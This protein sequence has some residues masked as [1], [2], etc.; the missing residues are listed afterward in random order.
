M[1]YQEVIS[2]IKGKSGVYDI[3]TL[4]G[5][6][7]RRLFLSQN[8]L[9]CEFAPRSRK[10]GYPIDS[11][12]IACWVSVALYT[13]NE[14]NIVAKF[15]RYASRATFPSAFVRKCLVAD[16]SK[17]CYENRLTT[18][19]R[20]D[21]EIISLNAIERFNPYSVRQ[22]RKALKER[23]NYHSSRFEFRGY[24]G[25]LWIEIAEQDDGYN[26]KGDV[27]AGFNKEYRNCGNGFYYSLIDDEHF[28]GTDID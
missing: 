15:K 18:G 28:I 7:R 2:T 14:S 16:T 4:H 6:E 26:S 25:S 9:I 22:F 19:T 8:N 24:D 20:I 1:E 12:I 21:G 3:I 5:K 17:D 11:T 23:V 10:R 13:P 27:M